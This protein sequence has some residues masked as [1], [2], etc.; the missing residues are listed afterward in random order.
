MCYYSAHSE[1]TL[2]SSQLTLSSL[3]LTL[4]SLQLTL[5]SSQLT[6]RVISPGRERFLCL[7]LLPTPLPDTPTVGKAQ[8]TITNKNSKVQITITMIQIQ[9]P[10]IQNINTNIKF[11]WLTHLV[12]EVIYR[13]SKIL[14]IIIILIMLLSLM[15]P[16]TTFI[17]I[18]DVFRLNFSVWVLFFQLCT[19]GSL[20]FV[21]GRFWHV[22][23][24]WHV[25]VSSARQICFYCCQSILIP[26]VPVSSGF[27]TK[28]EKSHFSFVPGF[29]LKIVV[30]SLLHLNRYLYWCI[31]K[32]LWSCWYGVVCYGM[33]CYVTV[34]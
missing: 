4:S 22:L 11:T 17:G 2:S 24:F 25:L 7:Q 8:N 5:S 32:Q 21:S 18:I 30:S 31:S 6:L 3:Q 14:I 27:R 20:A 34:R 15:S 28:M 26:K 9:N 19:Q 10:R 16:L 23:I 29:C 13:K 33:V 12:S 1:L